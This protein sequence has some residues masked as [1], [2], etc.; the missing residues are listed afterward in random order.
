M[1]SRVDGELSKKSFP[2]LK[3]ELKKQIPRITL[4]VLLAIIGTGI[5]LIQPL[6]FKALIDSAIPTADLKLIG[7]LLV[8]MVIV[9][10]IRAGLYSVNHYLRA[11]IGEGVAQRLRRELFDHLL[12][13]RG[14]FFDLYQ[15]QSFDLPRIAL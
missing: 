6:L 11:Y 2:L 3:E 4:L 12:A 10:V 1:R 9:P 13:R 14:L 5:G 15:A 8:G 7:L